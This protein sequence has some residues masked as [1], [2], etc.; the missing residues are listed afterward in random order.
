MG[1][2]RKAAPGVDGVT[3]D[4]YVDGRWDRLTDRPNRVPSGAYRALPSRRV[5]LPQ[6]DGGPRP[7][8]IAA[9]ED[10]I[11]QPAVCNLMLTPI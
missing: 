4:P 7:L 6:A 9:W 1:W 3:G 2:K 5:Y 11:I 10:Q 8:G